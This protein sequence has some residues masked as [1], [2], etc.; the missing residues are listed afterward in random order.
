MKGLICLLAMVLFISGCPSSGGNDTSQQKT[1]ILTL[2]QAEVGSYAELVIGKPFEFIYQIDSDIEYTQT[3]IVSFHL[4]EDIELIIDD[5]QVETNQEV[6]YSYFLGSQAIE[7][8]EQGENSFKYEITLPKG[9][10]PDRTYKIQ[11]VLGLDTDGEEPI[12]DHLLSTEIAVDIDFSSEDQ[13]NLVL[14]SLNP[15]EGIILIAAD[16]E[17]SSDP[18]T[19]IDNTELFA[20]VTVGSFRETEVDATLHLLLKV[21]DTWHTIQLWDSA[22]YSYQDS[23]VVSIGNDHHSLTLDA[24]FSD[25]L[26]D[27]VKDH[28]AISENNQLVLRAHVDYYNEFPETDE[29]DNYLD[30][31]V[32]VYL[33]PIANIGSRGSSLIGYHY[34]KKFNPLIGSKKKVGLE[35]DMDFDVGADSLPMPGVYGSADFT[36]KP[37]FHDHED[38][39]IDVN[40]LAQYRFKYPASGVDVMISTLGKT[41][42]HKLFTWEQIKEKISGD[43]SDG[44]ESSS[45]PICLAMCPETDPPTETPALSEKVTKNWYKE[46]EIFEQKFA[47]GPV[48]MEVQFGLKGEVDTDLEFGLRDNLYIVGQIP[49]KLEL[50]AYLRGGV[51]LEL[52]Y[53][54]IEG[55][56]DFVDFNAA[57]NSELVVNL[58]SYGSGDAKPTFASVEA[59]SDASYEIHALEGKLQLFYSLES[60]KWCKKHC[61]WKDWTYPCGFKSA[62]DGKRHYIPIYH[63]KA[64]YHKTDTIMDYDHIWGE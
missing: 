41:L 7:K 34:E 12:F 59:K 25:S 43:G 32:H 38:S 50:D 24:N 11:T 8:F 52:V 51:D 2:T 10:D 44:D 53:A 5:E 45:E 60:V 57:T 16:E 61:C 55:D 58:L 18:A 23:L 30:F 47:V 4:V 31:P 15:K 36:L 28:L 33:S 14:T 46:V 62:P 9:I 17:R 37:Y 49:K 21:D 39:F 64:A 6:N 29:T 35:I 1:A 48:P 20:E 63:T 13:V 19:R 54:G 3:K 40:A 22:T 26:V 27:T 42:F 56:L